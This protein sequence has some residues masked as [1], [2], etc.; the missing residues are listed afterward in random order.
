ML[1]PARARGVTEYGWLVGFYGI[2]TC[3]GYF[4]SNPVYTHVLD[5]YDL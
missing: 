2:S 3:V 1:H 4:M 5:I